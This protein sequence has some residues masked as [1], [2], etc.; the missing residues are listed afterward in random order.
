MEIHITCLNSGG[1][2]IIPPLV[3]T[4]TH[5]SRLPVMVS[6]TAAPAD[7]AASLARVRLWMNSPSRK[8]PTRTTVYPCI[9]RLV[10]FATCTHER[11]LNTRSIL[12]RNVD[13]INNRRSQNDTA[14]IADEGL[15]RKNH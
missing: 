1:A 11:A 8:L 10:L 3:V 13:S 6:P 2:S 5:A 12:T 4:T 15:H 9:G 14:T 7:V